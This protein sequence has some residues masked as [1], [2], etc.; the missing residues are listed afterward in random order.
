[1]QNDP[2]AVSHYD[3]P[4]D[5]PRNAGYEPPEYLYEEGPPP[6]GM[7]PPA[8]SGE[9][10]QAGSDITQEWP[11]P[12]IGPEQTSTTQPAAKTTQEAGSTHE[13]VMI[14]PDWERSEER[15]REA[16]YQQLRGE[17]EEIVRE[18][19]GKKAD[20]PVAMP[21]YRFAANDTLYGLPRPDV[22]REFYGLPAKEKH[23]EPEEPF[24]RKFNRGLEPEKAGGEIHLDY[25]F[26]RFNAQNE[27]TEVRKHVLNPSRML[28]FRNEA[29]F[30][31]K[32]DGS[33]I[34]IRKNKIICDKTDR[35]IQ[36]SLDIAQDMGWDVIKITGGSKTAKAEMWFQAQM[37]GLETRGYEPTETDKKRLLGAQ[38]R[39]RKEQAAH[40]GDI[41]EALD[42]KPRQ[43]PEQNRANEQQSQ[44]PPRPEAQT[45]NPAATMGNADHAN[46]SPQDDKSVNHSAQKSRNESGKDLSQAE[47]DEL[48]LD[49]R[50]A[51]TRRI[52]LSE[53][54]KLF[55]LDEKEYK[56]LENT[57]DQQ[58][59]IFARNGGR[60]DIN[61]FKKE[62]Q[63]GLPI[64]QK[65]LNNAARTEQNRKAHAE[66]MAEQQKPRTRE[67]QNDHSL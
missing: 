41:T 37:R 11:V 14:E 35:N 62:I 28:D 63:H 34:T 1:M 42:I 59:S 66:R 2:D 65:E 23:G 18:A 10:G 45:K 67:K 20:E 6:I 43:E 57:F 8:P 15:W 30:E 64:A 4:R 32:G 58:L 51:Y 36:S 47:F 50:I 5:D 19:T 16:M 33:R 12:D 29:V 61:K 38:E 39:E 24:K 31:H 60:M 52:M 9:Q 44:D 48:S 13:E 56:D 27:Y 3:D 49:Q 55:P 17:L 25:T 7:E 53:V 22:L 21:D 54:T 46:E 40:S 26:E